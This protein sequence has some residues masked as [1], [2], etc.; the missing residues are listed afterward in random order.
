MKYLDNSSV[1][2]DAILTKKG[3]E[4]L[5][6]PAGNF[7]IVKFA[8]GD[9]EVDYELYD[10]AN[11][12]GSSYYGQAIENMSVLE[13]DPNETK[14]MRFKLISLPINSQRMPGI[15]MDGGTTSFTIESDLAPPGLLLSPTTTNPA[16]GNT[17]L[18]YTATVND[19]SVLKIEGVGT[20]AGGGTSVANTQGI[21]TNISNKTVTATGTSFNIM[22]VPQYN[23]NK[24]TTIIITGNETGGYITVTV[25]VNKQTISYSATG[26]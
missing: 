5:S 26:Q 18:G 9:D 25:T 12:N 6:Q 11:T 24:S 20:N 1:T 21:Q 2:V 4:I 7:Q 10:P 17:T 16:N 3:R 13:A 19:G 14:T 8:V 23:E 22:P 15:S